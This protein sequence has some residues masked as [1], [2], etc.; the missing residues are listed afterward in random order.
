MF[1]IYIKVQNSV[2]IFCFEKHNMCIFFHFAANPI[3]TFPKNFKRAPNEKV[4]HNVI[5]FIH[6]CSN[7]IPTFP[8]NF[9]C[10]PNEKST[11][12]IHIKVQNSFK[13]F[14]FEIN[15]FFN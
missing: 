8:K 11:F 13:F 9:K 12:Q 14:T 7:P 3:L 2:I 6:I 1:W 15:Y 10:G 4:S 5:G